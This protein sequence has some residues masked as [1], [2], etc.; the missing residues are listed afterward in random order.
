MGAGYGS[1]DGIVLADIAVIVG[2]GRCVHRLACDVEVACSASVGEDA[3]VTDAM[4]AVGDDVEQEASDE[5]L[6]GDGDGAVARSFGLPGLSAPEGDGAAVELEDAAVG[7]GDPVGVS[8]KVN[9]KDLKPL[10]N[11]PSLLTQK[12]HHNRHIGRMSM[13][14]WWTSGYHYVVLT[15]STRVAFEEILSPTTT[16]FGLLPPNQQE[17]LTVMHNEF[18][19]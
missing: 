16:S 8:Q 6:G 12:R 13:P 18:T 15:W 4:H 1:D 17:R 9:P 10:N 5:L 7:D 3:E 14:V 19:V 2:V 11:A